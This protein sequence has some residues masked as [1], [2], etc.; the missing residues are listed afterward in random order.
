MYGGP[1]LTAINGV[2]FYRIYYVYILLS[3]KDNKLY[4]GF[5]SDLKRRLK[6]HNDGK[7]RAQNPADHLN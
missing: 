7:T 6:E 1:R 5:T 2:F 4:I 3:E